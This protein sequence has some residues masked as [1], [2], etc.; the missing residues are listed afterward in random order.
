MPTT[1]TEPTLRDKFGGVAD[2]ERRAAR[3]KY[4][5][6]RVT[7]VDRDDVSTSTNKRTLRAA[8]KYGR[9]INHA[10]RAWADH[11]KLG[12]RVARSGL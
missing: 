10:L 8:V 9:A 1:T 11:I 2:L 5:G 12:Q 6:S 4:K 3:R 7:L